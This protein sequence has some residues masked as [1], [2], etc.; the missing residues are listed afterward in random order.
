M[1][2]FTWCVHEDEGCLRFRGWRGR[3][4]LGWWLLQ[5]G[6][7][8]YSENSKIDKNNIFTVVLVVVLPGFHCLIGTLPNSHEHLLHGGDWHTKAADAKR[9]LLGYKTRETTISIKN[10]R[11][12]ITQIQTLLPGLQEL[13]ISYGLMRAYKVLLLQISHALCT[14]SLATVSSCELTCLQFFYLPDD[15]IAEETDEMR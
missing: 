14:T 9:L 6:P 7:S 3:T 12:N 11:F 5:R 8:I 10:N 4:V 15:Q 13:I 1:I 2:Q